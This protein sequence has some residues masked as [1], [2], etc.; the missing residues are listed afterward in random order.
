MNTDTTFSAIQNLTGGTNTQRRSTD[1]C[2]VVAQVP[3]SILNVAANARDAMPDG[4]RFSIRLSPH[5]EGGVAIAL[6]DT[7]HGMDDAVRQRIFE[8]FFSMKS[9]TGG[10]GLGL[11]VIH[12]MILASGGTI[13]VESAPG[14]GSTFHVRVPDPTTP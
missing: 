2:D 6:S 3:E 14:E 1:K 4:G 10:T 5:P 9:G 8:P 13:V 11:S 7:G 12:D